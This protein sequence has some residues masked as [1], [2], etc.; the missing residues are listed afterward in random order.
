MAKKKVFHP[1]RNDAECRPA[2][3]EIKRCFDRELEPDAPAADL[4]GER[5]TVIEKDEHERELVRSR[6]LRPR[7]RDGY[8]S[9]SV[10]K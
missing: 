8:S 9:F 10:V 5:A 2:L 3:K 1:L 4:L 7:N 6:G